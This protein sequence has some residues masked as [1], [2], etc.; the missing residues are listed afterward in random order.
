MKTIGTMH[1]A[2]AMLMVCATW[3]MGQPVDKQKQAIITPQLENGKVYI[4]T[5]PA[6]GKPEGITVPS[7]YMEGQCIDKDK[8]ETRQV[9]TSGCCL[10]FTT[11]LDRSPGWCGVAWSKAP[12]GTN[13]GAFADTPSNPVFKLQG[14]KKLVIHLRGQR[15]GE[16]VQIKV[17]VLGDKPYGDSL[18][19]PIES[20]WF[21]LTSE[22]KSFE[23]VIPDSA[24]LSRVYTPLCWVANDVH[25]PAGMSTITFYIDD[26]YFEF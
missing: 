7:L 8:P 26:C 15:G 17:G 19:Y 16:S 6:D 14:A 13:E 5:G 12:S 24:D 21:K 4:Y 2:A 23:I 11:H 20:P 18:R 25:Q 10:K 9:S 3:S 1:T 22:W